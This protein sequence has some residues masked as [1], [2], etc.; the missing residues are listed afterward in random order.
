MALSPLL[1]Q[2]GIEA[3]QVPET[4]GSVGAELQVETGNL[5]AHVTRSSGVG[6]DD[7]LEAA[8]FSQKPWPKAS[9]F[10]PPD[11]AS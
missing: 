7:H 10:P 6:C 9:H 3:H 1:G 2:A 11:K 5:D 8:R 4:E